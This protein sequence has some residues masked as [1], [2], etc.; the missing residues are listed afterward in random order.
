MT[1]T[2]L[3]L[4]PEEQAIMDG[5][6]GPVMARAM[7]SIVLYGEAFGAGKLVDIEGS[8]HLVT[9][10]GVSTMKPYFKMMD[11]LIEAGLKARDPFTVDPRPIEYE[12]VNVNPLQKIVNTFVYGKQADYEKQLRALGLKNDNSF[13][14]ACYFPEVGNR[15]QKGAMLSW[16]ESSAVV[17]ANSVLGAR[18]N[19]NSAGI[20]ILCAIL[21]KA[22][23]FGLLTDAG[24]RATW[25]IEVKT[26][27]RPNAQL[28]GSAIGLKV[29][30]DVPYI[31]GLER[32]LGD[33]ITPEVEAYLKDMGAASASNG[34]VGLYHVAGLTPEAKENADSLLDDGY[35]TYFIDDAELERVYQSYPQLWSNPDA[36]PKRVFV[37]C[38]HLNRHQLQQWIERITA[39][40]KQQ[41]LVRCK[42]QVVL[43]TAPDVAALF[44][45]DTAQM[46]SLNAMNVTITTICPLMYMNNPLCARDPIAT[47]SN[48]L[49]T[50]STARFLMD[51]AVL[52]LICS[53]RVKSG[54]K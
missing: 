41:N 30:E 38:P 5:S 28:L 19:R 50:Y 39:T 53:G 2:Q 14:C 20:D 11:E 26:S 3:I 23:Y 7:K 27:R 48:K 6:Q 18:T 9:S 36:T 21:G 4:T 24:R 29:M 31:C 8:Q 1:P 22:P 25:K 44:R 42:V 17:F 15:P 12:A 34:A 51:D 47:N 49:R 16:S 33:E 46:Q 40:L 32:F 10:F 54:G 52:E 37:G 35:R 45:K 13:T 43:S